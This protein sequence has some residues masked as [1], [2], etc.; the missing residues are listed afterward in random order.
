[1]W[2]NIIVNNIQTKESILI[3]PYLS[4]SGNCEEAFTWYA[5]IFGGKITHLSRYGDIPADPDNPL[6][7]EINRQVMHAELELADGGKISGAD[8]LT[9]LASG[10][11]VALHASLPLESDA[12]ETFKALSNEGTVIAP[13]TTNP[14]PDDTGVSGALVD[15]YGFTWIISGIKE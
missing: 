13:L 11:T 10:S 12:E 15:R 7:E 6:G 14:P 2:K 8:S 3:S 1:M 4:F 5:N 9:P